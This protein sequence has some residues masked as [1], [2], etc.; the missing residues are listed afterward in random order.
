MVLPQSFEIGFDGLLHLDDHLGFV[1][2]R[3]GC[4]QHHHADVAEVLVR[5]TALLAGALLDEHFVTA[6]HQF[7]TGRGNKSDSPL[8]GFQ[9]TGNSNTHGVCVLLCGPD[10]VARPRDPQ[11]T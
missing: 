7:D 11:Q 3:V 8:S 6:A 9:L 4:R 1:E 2:E 10:R 5:V